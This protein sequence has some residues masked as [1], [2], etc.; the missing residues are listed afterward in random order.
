MMAEAMNALELIALS[1]DQL[2]NKFGY[3]IL[4]LAYDILCTCSLLGSINLC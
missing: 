2:F 4:Y 1:N 3:N